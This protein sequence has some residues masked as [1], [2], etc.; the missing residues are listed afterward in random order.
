MSASSPAVR[1]S[2]RIGEVAEL[3]GT[4]PRT[5]RYYEEIGLLPGYGDRAQG[6]HRAYTQGDVERVR[7]IVRL[8][9]LLG[10]SLDALSRLLEA[11]SARAELRRE[12]RQAE[13]PDERR[14][15]LSDS[16]GHIATQLELVRARKGEL[17]RLEHELA[18]KRRS[19]RKRLR[20][21]EE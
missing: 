11:E 3:T 15:I 17:E 7:E 9:D 12:W 4:T 1:R 20:D 14:R 16:L 18:D 13:E 19:V 10:L 8:R 21:L 6:K 2:L 5:I